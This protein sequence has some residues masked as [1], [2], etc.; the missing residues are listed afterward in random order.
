M[1]DQLMYEL[2]L[3]SLLPS[4]TFEIDWVV[5]GI[6]W[7]I[8]QQKRPRPKVP[9]GSNY[10]TIGFKQ[11]WLSVREIKSLPQTFLYFFAYFLLADGLN[12]TGK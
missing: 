3:L 9:K 6:W 1:P 8:F 5:L 11:I 2:P 10:L 7:F 12:T 4:L